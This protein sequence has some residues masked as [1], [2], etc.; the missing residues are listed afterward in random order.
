MAI[1][2]GSQEWADKVCEELNSSQIY[3]EAAKNWEG[4]MYIIVEP[5]ATFK[6]RI[7]VYFDLWHGDCRSACIVKDENEKSPKYRICGPFAIMKQILDKKVDS[8]QAMMTG[9]LKVK[10]DMAQ[11]MRMPRA[12]VEF[13]NGMTTF[14]TVFP[15]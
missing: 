11:I 4:D 12:A 5:D 9:R 2:F 3:K 1:L 6:Q 7:I 8:V 14:E 15:D 10:G 13:V